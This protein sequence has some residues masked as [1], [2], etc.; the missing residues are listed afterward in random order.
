MVDHVS[1]KDQLQKELSQLRK[2]VVMLEQLQAVLNASFES[3]A[4]GLLVISKDG[5]IVSYNNKFL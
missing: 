4:D 2:K 5:N 3:T 1:S